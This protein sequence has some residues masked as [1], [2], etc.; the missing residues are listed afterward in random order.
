MEFQRF[1]TIEPSSQ[2]EPE[3]LAG[4]RRTMLKILDYVDTQFDPEEGLLPL[5]TFG[6]ITPWIAWQLGIVA[7]VHASRNEMQQA[8]YIAFVSIAAAYACHSADRIYA[9]L[10]TMAGI[11]VRLGNTEEAIS[12]YNRLLQLPY[13]GG[14]REKALAHISLAGLSKSEAPETVLY[15]YERGLRQVQQLLSTDTFNGILSQASDL[16]ARTEEITGAIYCIKQLNL[17]DTETMVDDYLNS[18]KSFDDLLYLYTRLNGF[19]EYS[20]ADRVYTFWEEHKST[21]Q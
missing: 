16:Y 6:E 3:D 8:F 19:G 14:V 13:D 21:F 20:L 10:L 2:P 17:A 15:H 9:N 18:L 5:E 11:F 4:E 1:E 7:E 12:T